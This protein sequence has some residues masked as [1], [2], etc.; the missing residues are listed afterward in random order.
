LVVDLDRQRGFYYPLIWARGR[1][2]G[3][4][5][6]TP[7]VGRYVLIAWVVAD[8][9]AGEG[10][11][12]VSYRPGVEVGGRGVVEDRHGAMA[13]WMALDRAVILASRMARLSVDP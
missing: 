11:A 8:R 10:G 5:D 1:R 2:S 6:D 9:Q 4:G 13:A 12:E 3:G 7:A